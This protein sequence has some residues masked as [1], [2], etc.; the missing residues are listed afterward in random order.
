MCGSSWLP[1]PDVLH[2]SELE[3]IDLRALSEARVTRLGSYLINDK[4]TFDKLTAKPMSELS[5]LTTSSILILY[6]Q[7]KAL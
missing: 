7:M 2:G 3:P 4:W 1:G 5:F 6:F